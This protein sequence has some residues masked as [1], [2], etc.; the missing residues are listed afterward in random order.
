MDVVVVEDEGRDD[1][2]NLVYRGRKTL[3]VR[4]APREA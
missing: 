1:Q 2:G 3:I 4:P